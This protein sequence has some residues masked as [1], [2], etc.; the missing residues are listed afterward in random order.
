MT[1]PYKTIEHTADIGIEVSGDSLTDLFVNAAGGMFSLV[2]KCSSGRPLW[3]PDAMAAT[4][5][6]HYVQKISLKANIKE[7]LLVKW[8]EELLYFFEIKKLVP[9]NFGTLDLTDKKLVAEVSCAPFDPE[10]YHVKHQIKA[11]TYHNLAIIEKNGR[12]SAKIIFDI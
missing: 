1:T 10:I 4:E 2:L 6:R 3:R 9:V 7:E 5:G 8:L 11:V 12:F